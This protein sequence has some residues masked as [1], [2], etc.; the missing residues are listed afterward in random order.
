MTTTA[1]RRRRTETPAPTG[2]RPRVPTPRRFTVD[3]YTRMLEIGLFGHN[4][5]IELLDGEILN[6]A[7]QG[8]PHIECIMRLSHELVLSGGNDFYVSQQSGVRLSPY[9]RPE[10][11]IALVPRDRYTGG[12]PRAEAVALI[13][14]VAETTLAYDRGRKLAAYAAA[15]I[16]E[17]WVVNLRRRE[18]EVYREPD[19][20]AFRTATVVPADGR[21]TPLALPELSLFVADVVPEPSPRR[22]RRTR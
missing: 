17:Y 3:E 1:P 8:D 4:P 7:A 2:D 9:S 19:G 6:M 21:L 10:P 11:D 18:V 22:A 13:V 20:S 15:G 16:P 5:H 14:E 12:A